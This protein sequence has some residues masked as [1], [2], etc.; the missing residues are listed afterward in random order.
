MKKADSISNFVVGPLNFLSSV[1]SPFVSLLTAS[2]NF[3]VRL[4]GVDPSEKMKNYR[5]GNSYARRYRRRKGTID[6]SE[7]EMIN[8]ILNLITRL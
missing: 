3:V 4:F 5:R 8:N 1:T 2:T 7:R 6:Q